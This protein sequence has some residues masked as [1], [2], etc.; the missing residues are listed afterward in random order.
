[1]PAAPSTISFADAANEQPPLK[2][3]F[4]REGD[5]YV[6]GAQRIPVAVVTHLRQLAQDAPIELRDLPP[7]IPVTRQ[8]V[9][10]AEG[11]I[12]EAALLG[13]DDVPHA[14]PDE[15]RHLVSFEAVRRVALAKLVDDGEHDTFWSSLTVDLGGD[16]PITLRTASEAPWA[17]PWHVEI[18]TEKRTVYSLE[19]SKAV[20]LFADPR[21][22]SARFLNGTDYWQSEFWRDDDLWDY[23]V[24][25]HLVAHRAREIAGEL[26]GYDEASKRFRVTDATIAHFTAGHALRIV[27]E[28]TER[29]LI[30]EARWYNVYDGG[31]PGYDWEDFLQRFDALARAAETIPFF[32]TWKAAGTDRTLECDIVG[33][34]AHRESNPEYFIRGAWHHS[35][36]AGE[37]EFA[38]YLH[39]NDAWVATLYFSPHATGC[40]VTDAAEGVLPDGREVSFHPKVGDYAVI[41]PDGKVAHRHMDPVPRG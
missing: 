38:L 1:M 32:R 20:A 18:G 21:G 33:R 34:T 31:K 41:T 22:Y 7:E 28:A 27:V 26:A 4:R 30:D 14:I 2:Y 6:R 25:T 12:V 16:P 17:Q 29:S 15:L 23:H 8:L 39:V 35:E 19:I 37:P 40:L 36:L 10:R 9:E 11:T 13:L 3:S 5:V 24:G